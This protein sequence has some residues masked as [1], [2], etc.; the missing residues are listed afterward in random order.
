MP[1]LLSLVSMRLRKLVDCT[2]LSSLPLVR[3]YIT[4]CLQTTASSYVEP[5]PLEATYVMSCLKAYG[6]ASGQMINLQ[7]SSIIFG[8]KV[9]HDAKQEVKGILGIDQEGGEGSYSGLPECFSGSKVKMLNFLKEKLQGRLRG[10]FSKSLSQGG[11]EILLKSVALALPIYAMSCFKLPEDVCAKLTSA[12]VE[13]WWSFGNN[14]KKIPLVAWKKLCKDKVLGGLGFKDIEKFNQ[15][16]LAKKAWRIWSNP[17]SLVARILKQ[18][19]FARADFLDCRIGTRPSYAWRSII[20]G[21]ELL[22]QGLYH[23]IGS[24]ETTN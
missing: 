20:H 15:A 24:G 1:K 3:Q 12:M 8:S 19:Y 10:W 21:R 23:K 5:I 9:P 6:D 4:F 17:E 18:R 14:K 2:V 11:K 16:L 22:S 13:F 7:K